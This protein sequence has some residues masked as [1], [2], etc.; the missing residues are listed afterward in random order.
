MAADIARFNVV[1]ADDSALADYC[2]LR[3][4]IAAADFPDDPPPTAESTIGRLRAP[5]TGWGRREHWLAQQDDEAV[6][7][8]TIG[9]LDEGKAHHGQAEIVVHPAVRRRG[10]GRELLRAVLPTV[11]ENSLPLVEGWTVR[12]N[13][14]ELW[15]AALGFR[16]VHETA[17]QELVLA[18]ADADR[19]CDTAPQGYQLDRWVGAAPARLLTSYAEAKTA[20]D[21]APLGDAS[22]RPPRWTPERV[23]AAE[24]DLRRRQVEHRVVIAS[25]ATTGTVAAVTELDIYSY[26]PEIGYQGDTAV[27]TAHRGHGLGHCVKSRMLQWLRVERPGLERIYTSTAAANIHM[28]RVNREIGFTVFRRAVE[29]EQEVGTLESRLAV[30]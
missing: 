23:R 3:S 7:F 17:L 25:Q 9:I 28:L 18:D 12:G 5:L 14:G 15:A 8:A 4:A 13:P 27:L 24:D 21:D 6:G 20:I 29:F 16:V 22:Y 1:T 10:L 2:R 19:W 30:R 11:R 26:R